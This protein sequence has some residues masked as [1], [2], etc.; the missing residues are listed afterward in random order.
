MVEQANGRLEAGTW[1]R[2]RVIRTTCNKGYRALAPAFF[3]DAMEAADGGVTTI[4]R[5]GCARMIADA[6]HGTARNYRAS[7]Y[8]NSASLTEQVAAEGSSSPTLVVAERDADHP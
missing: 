8:S 3:G 5:N 4:R 6:I 1:E 7:T 2:R